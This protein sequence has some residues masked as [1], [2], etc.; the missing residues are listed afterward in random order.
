VLNKIAMMASCHAAS[1][2]D[3]S[4]GGKSKINS[5]FKLAIS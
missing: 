1:K 4:P 3:F 5:E 2:L